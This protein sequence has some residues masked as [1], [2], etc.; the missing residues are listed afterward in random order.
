MSAK[1]Y[2]EVYN[3]MFAGIF[4]DCGG[5]EGLPNF[6]YGSY[7]GIA[8]SLFMMIPS[9]AGMTEK[10]SA[11]EITAAWERGDAETLTRKITLQLRACSLIACPACFGAAAL[12]QPIMQTLYRTRSAEISVCLRSF[13]ILCLGGIFMVLASSMFG[14]F[15]SIGKAHVPLILM[16]C[17]V[18][19]KLVLNPILISIPSLN[20]AG[21]AL[22]SII[23]YV[24]MTI[25]G[26][27]KLKKYLPQKI[28][29]PGAV[30]PTL[31]CGIGCGAAAF[32]AY[33]LLDDRLSG[34][35]NLFVSV[36]IGAVFYVF[37]LILT[38]VFR[39]NG[40]IKR[41]NVKNFQKPLAKRDKIG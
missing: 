21:A 35:T 37:L 3:E 30:F 33:K 1:M 17:S 27:L 19:I 6:M 25:G 31:L 7:T 14:I 28:S 9:F 10:T 18:L 8:M 15:Q 4:A 11:P 23:G 12:A 2:P 34:V 13:V 29:L 32:F 24:F 41:K 5:I 39:T 36:I 26:A 22:S 16:L 40:I 20:I 38:G